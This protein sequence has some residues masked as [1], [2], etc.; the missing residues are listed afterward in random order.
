MSRRS[1]RQTLHLPARVMRQLPRDVEDQELHALHCFNHARF[2][3]APRNPPA[4]LPFP[5]AGHR[6]EMYPL[7]AVGK[8]ILLTL[9]NPDGDAGQRLRVRGLALLRIS[10]GCG[11]PNGSRVP[12][13][14]LSTAL[15]NAAPGRYPRSPSQ[16]RRNPMRNHPAQS[17]VFSQPLE[18]VEAL[19][20]PLSSE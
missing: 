16:V 6:R 5:D 12:S 17:R 11:F 2:L 18:V 9:P 4:G 19:A 15:C 10:T 8:Q 13:G 3:P 7:A 1:R 14:A 20:P